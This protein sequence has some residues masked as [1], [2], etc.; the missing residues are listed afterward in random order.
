[1][2]ESG[3]GRVW[4][5]AAAALLLGGCAGNQTTSVEVS[6]Q[7]DGLNERSVA[8]M[9]WA[10]ER[11]AY[12]HPGVAADVARAVSRSIAHG[13]PGVSLVDP[14]QVAAYQ[15]ADPHW[16]SAM[17]GELVNAMGVQR[18]VLIELVDFRLTE[19]GNRHVF[20]G[21]ARA[22]VGVSAAESPDP[23]NFRFFVSDVEV[24]FPPDADT[25][26]G[27]INADP[28]TIRLGLL[29]AVARDIGGLFY[30]HSYEQ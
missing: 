6:A 17:P 1:M 4:L 22:N 3:L 12:R 7:Y 25:S 19:P 5:I 2:A 18:L 15:E 29:Q 16:A 24:R 9:V 11:T 30:D 10:D 20:R 13:V 8:V 14:A 26:I 27:V 23:D 28:Q 21:L